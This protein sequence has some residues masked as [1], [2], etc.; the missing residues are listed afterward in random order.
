MA[1]YGVFACGVAG[2]RACGGGDAGGWEVAG[3]A[4]AT[5]WGHCLAISCATGG[6]DILYTQFSKLSPSPPPLCCLLRKFAGNGLPV[7][8]SLPLSP[9]FGNIT[10]GTGSA[11]P[12]LGLG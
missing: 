2:C 8:Y 10:M 12:H 11:L 3:G 6:R 1:G 9:L 5:L 7:F 4:M